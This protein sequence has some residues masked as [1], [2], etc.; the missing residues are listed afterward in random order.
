MPFMR[1]PTLLLLATTA[2]VAAPAL[3]QQ[4]PIIQPGA[5]GAPSKVI[6]AADASKLVANRYLP[7]DVEFM[8]AM[9][10]H[11]AQ[12]LEMSKLVASRTTSKEAN[13]AAT[14]I[15]KSQG[16]EMRFMESWLRQRGQP[17]A[18]DHSMHMG[19]AMGPHATMTGMASPADLARLASLKGV[20]FERLFYT[21]MIKHH[22]GALEMISALLKVP[23]AAYDPVLFEFITDAKNDQT[24]EIERMEG[25]LAQIST[26]PRFGLKAGFNNAGQAI[27]N[28]TLLA[29]LPKPAGFFDPTN[30]EAKPLPLPV[31]KGEKPS[32]EEQFSDRFP[33][34]SFAQTDMAFDK[35]LLF[36]GNYHGFNIYRLGAQGLPTLVSSTVCPGGQG[37]VSV[38]GKL[39]I[40]SV[41]QTRGRVDCGLQG[42]DVP[43]SPERFRG[44]RIFDISDPTRPRQVGLVQTCRGSH[45][46]S[47][48]DANDKRAIVYVSGT[49]GVRDE[50]ELAGCVGNIAGDPR[51]ALFSIDV[52][53]I[54]FAD[55]S[56]ARI[57]SSPRVF[58][59]PKTGNVA[60]LWKGG[61]HGVGTQ[62]TAQTNQCHDITAFPA[63]KIAAGACSGNGIILDISDPMKPRRIHDVT[64][65]GFA[66]WHSATFNNDG[67][68]VLFT[69]EWGGGGMPRCRA[70]DPRN[71]G[72]DAFYDIEGGQ[73]VR[74][75]TYKL[76]AP[77]TDKENC[78]AHNGSAVPVPGR[79]I[80]VQA[81]YQGGISL[82]DFTNSSNPYEIGYFDRGPLDAKHEAL[83]GFW[84]AYYYKGRVYGTEIARGLDVLALKPSPQLSANEI[85]A[86]ALA[87]SDGPFNPQN[88]YPMR[89][90]AVPVVARAY[91]DQLVR[92]NAIDAATR[93]SLETALTQADARL[94]ANAKD[95]ALAGQINA[96]AGKM[97]GGEKQADLASVL[98]GIAA[99]LR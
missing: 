17:A 83:G 42:I 50:K 62:D 31:K 39:L 89:W 13:A 93:G 63:K 82:I 66:Y 73:L 75:G 80:F 77:Q 41:E 12:A 43:V 18:M 87:Y 14:R 52:V 97:G 49:A 54:P 84:S 29:S 45:T 59:D 90:P 6:S 7:A 36:T 2:L 76:P 95:A 8:Q 30:P 34:L 1:T 74:K 57:V 3:A 27:S 4:A 44:I 35:D 56:K 28:M 94:A 61:D 40:M 79:D 51:T 88:Q 69:D 32:K 70:T 64:D 58:A 60:G 86:A 71:F 65:P 85:A 25:L 53:E 22:Q 55:P 15:L 33:L 48:I 16:D 21:L 99:K 78:V 68:K 20:D 67:S 5:P 81:W 24:S 91:V 47:V 38:V 9:I 72:A 98:K 19:M 11:H 26:D 10:P 92:A 46:H 37:D 96:M 23:G